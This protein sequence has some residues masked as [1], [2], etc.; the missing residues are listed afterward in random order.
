MVLVDP[1]KSTLKAPGTKR[2]K[3]KYDKLL[4]NFAFNFNLRR[5]KEELAVTRMRLVDADSDSNDARSWKSVCSGGGGTGAGDIG[6]GRCRFPV[7]V[8]KLVLKAGLLSAL[9]TEI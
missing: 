7:R 9:E 5:Y 6:V 8:S 2:L 4:S 3:L 1:F